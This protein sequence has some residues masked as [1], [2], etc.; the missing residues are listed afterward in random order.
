MIREYGSD[1]GYTRTWHP[2]P[3]FITIQDDSAVQ[4]RYLLALSRECYES[5]RVGDHWPSES[6]ECAL[7]RVVQPNDVLFGSE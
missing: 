1:Y 3:Y 6:D 5:V 4:E 7:E 2:G